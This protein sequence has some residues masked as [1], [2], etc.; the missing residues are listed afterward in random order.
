MP[1]PRRWNSAK[2]GDRVTVDSRAPRAFEIHPLPTVLD[3]LMKRS[4]VCHLVV[5]PSD[6]VRFPSVRHGRR[7]RRRRAE[8]RRVH[9]RPRSV[10]R[11]DGQ[12]ELADGRRV[13]RPRVRNVARVEFL[14]ARR[15]R[16]GRAVRDRARRGRRPRVR[17]SGHRRHGRE[18]PRGHVRGSRRA[19]TP[20]GDDRG[21][22][23]DGS[24]A[25]AR[26]RRSSRRSAR[27]LLRIRIFSFSPLDA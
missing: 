20:N 24:R 25:Q 5:I 12:D 4:R 14:P 26:A 2:R 9:R 18:R 22:D 23:R 27:H 15:P 6:A 1:R 13:S 19:F 11:T 8:G 17:R 21:D 10:P 3:I 16:R 7:R